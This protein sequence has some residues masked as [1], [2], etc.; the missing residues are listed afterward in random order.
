MTGAVVLDLE[1]ANHLT[2]VLGGI[3]KFQ[4][5]KC[6]GDVPK[7]GVVTYVH[8]IATGRHLA[9]VALSESPEEGV[10]EGVL[11]E[12]TERLLLNLEGREVG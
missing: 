7:S 8:G 9:S 6:S 4:S 12:V 3:L 5:V 1:L 11:L 10:G 2:S